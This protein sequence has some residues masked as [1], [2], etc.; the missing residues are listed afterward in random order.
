M[1]KLYNDAVVEIEQHS[2]EP[3]L[4]MSAFPRHKCLHGIHLVRTTLAQICCFL[5]FISPLIFHD[6]LQLRTFRGILAAQS[7]LNRAVLGL[8]FLVLSRLLSRSRQPVL[9]FFLFSMITRVDGRFVRYMRLLEFGDAT[10][11]G[12]KF[13]ESMS[14]HSDTIYVEDY[15]YTKDT[16]DT[17]NSIRKNSRNH[18]D[19]IATCKTAF[20]VLKH[21]SKTLEKTRGVIVVMMIQGDGV[22]DKFFDCLNMEPL[23]FERVHQQFRKSPPISFNLCNKFWAS[24]RSNRDL[25][26]SEQLSLINS[27]EPKFIHFPFTKDGYDWH[28]KSAKQAIL[29]D[30]YELV[31]TFQLRHTQH[32][33]TPRKRKSSSVH[34]ARSHR[35]AIAHTASLESLK[36]QFIAK[37]FCRLIHRD[38]MRITVVW[39]AYDACSGGCY[40]LWL[41]RMYHLFYVNFQTHADSHCDT[42]RNVARMRIRDHQCLQLVRAE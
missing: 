2:A 41:F 23:F 37:G 10:G 13:I 29:D 6:N 22:D 25:Q 16:Q 32:T 28:S 34:A 42:H 1:A 17:L 14:Q 11:L 9:L 18:K 36:H 24:Y 15:Q 39:N 21:Q 30:N 35:S 8:E 19:D 31:Q 27:L 20:E 40:C 7:E 3:V 33:S 5:Y 26:L 38:K 12:H 4:E